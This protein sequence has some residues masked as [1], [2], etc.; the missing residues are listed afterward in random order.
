MNFASIVATAQAKREELT[1][2]AGQSTTEE[3]G[4]FQ[5]SH[6]HAAVTWENPPAD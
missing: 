5:S 3:K 4:C 1:L 6:K 2:Q